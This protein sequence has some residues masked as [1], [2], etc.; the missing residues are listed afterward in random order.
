[1]QQI[2]KGETQLHEEIWRLPDDRGVVRYVSDHFVN[3]PSVRA[4]SDKHGEPGEIL[5]DLKHAGLPMLYFGVL[6]RMVGS[7]DKGARIYGLR[8]LASVITNFE[9]MVVEAFQAA[10]KDPDLDLRALALRLIARYPY[11]VFEKNLEELARTESDAA[12]KEEALHLA[13]GL[14]KHGKVMDI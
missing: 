12:I 5:L 13:E 2:P 10:L 7:T 8:A 1:M 9:Y 3:V 14:R 4:E 6:Q 11:K